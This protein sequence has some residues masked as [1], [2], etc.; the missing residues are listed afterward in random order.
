MRILLPNQ[1]VVRDFHASVYD[2][3]VRLELVN[4]KTYHMCLDLKLSLITVVLGNILLHHHE[5]YGPCHASRCLASSIQTAR[6]G[7]R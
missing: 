3:K 5:S 2:E 4:G 6:Q 7:L 1:D